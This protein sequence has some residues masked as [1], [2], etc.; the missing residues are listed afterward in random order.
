MLLVSSLFVLFIRWSNVHAYS[1]NGEAGCNPCGAI[2]NHLCLNSPCSC[3]EPDLLCSDECETMNGCSQ[4]ESINSFLASQDHKCI[5]CNQF[6]GDECLHC[7][8][9]LG[10]QQCNSQCQRIQDAQCGLW[11]C[12]CDTTPSPTPSLT[13]GTV[14]EFLDGSNVE[15]YLSRF[16]SDC[17]ACIGEWGCGVDVF[18][19]WIS[20]SGI[21]D[22]GTYGIV[23]DAFTND[24]MYFLMFYRSCHNSILGQFW[25]KGVTVNLINENGIAYDTR[26]MFREWDVLEFYLN[27]YLNFSGDY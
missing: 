5:D 15:N 12:D 23:T 25:F 18:Y 17:Y 16:T 11:Y 22:L 27:Q 7:T 19:K 20:L 4:C 13:V 8:N 26:T 1:T 9:F 2:K 14:D 3:D 10:C 6:F 21:C 24:N